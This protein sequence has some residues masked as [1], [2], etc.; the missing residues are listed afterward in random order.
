MAG[1]EAGSNLAA[2]SVKPSITKDSIK[3]IC[4]ATTVGAALLS[5]CKIY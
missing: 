3:P 1:R 2:I 4:K 5:C